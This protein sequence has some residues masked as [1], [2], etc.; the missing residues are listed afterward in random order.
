[1]TNSTNSS[2]FKGFFILFILISGIILLL[3]FLNSRFLH[4]L[5]WPIQIFFFFL[6]IAGHFIASLGLKQKRDFHIFY[7]LSMG[8]RL[9]CCVIFVAIILTSFSDKPILFVG[10]FF[11]LY[12]VYT[13]FEIYF[14]LR[15]LR[16]DFKSD[17]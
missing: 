1:M 7:M 12:L 2:F 13:S 10:N 16:A 14:L 8:I 11:I 4:S 9:F 15:N 6:T 17:E 5:I 3:D